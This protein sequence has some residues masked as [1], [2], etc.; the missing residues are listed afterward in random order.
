LVIHQQACIAWFNAC[1][2]LAG[3]H[4]QAAEAHLAY[5]TA[6]D[7]DV[8]NPDAVAAAIAVGTAHLAQLKASVASASSVS[9]AQWKT[10]V[11]SA[12]SVDGRT[13]VQQTVTFTSLPD[14]VQPLPGA[15]ELVAPLLGAAERLA[16]TDASMAVSLQQLRVTSRSWDVATQLAAARSTAL[17]AKLVRPMSGTYTCI[18]ADA[19]IIVK[20]RPGCH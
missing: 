9:T 12:S 16:A 14:A 3:V 8:L 18:R 13:S 11:A 6:P 10:S 2:V 5:M 4:E 17:N 7:A 19:H 1:G 20:R 15:G